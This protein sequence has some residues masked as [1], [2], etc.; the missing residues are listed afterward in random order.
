M[1]AG[2]LR[3]HITLLT[4]QTGR[5]TAGQPLDAWDESNPIWADVQMIG[6]REQIRAGREVSEG[7]YSIRIRYR[8]NVTTAQRIKLAVSGEA[9]DITLV[10]PDQRRAWLIITAERVDL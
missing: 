10:Q 6:G 2:R 8:P 9:L 5:D 4:R 1:P 3:D 7:Q